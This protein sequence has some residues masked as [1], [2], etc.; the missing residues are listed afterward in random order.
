MLMRRSSKKRRSPK[1][2]GRETHKR[3]PLKRETRRPK[4]PR[5]KNRTWTNP[6]VSPPNA[7]PRPRVSSL[8]DPAHRVI[9]VRPVT[10]ARSA[11][12]TDPNV[13]QAPAMIAPNVPVR[14][15]QAPHAT[16]VRRVPVRPVQ[17]LPAHAHR[18]RA[19]HPA[20][21]ALAMIVR[22]A[23]ARAMIV[24]HVQDHPV[25]DHPAPAPRAADHPDQDRP[26][27]DPRAADRPEVDHPVAAPA[28]DHPAAGRVKADSKYRSPAAPQIATPTV[29]T[30]QAFHRAP[31]PLTPSVPPR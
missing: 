14:P 11:P 28:Q 8:R 10:T 15:D 9:S 13:S 1:I 4:S 22:N 5:L 23:P 12:A 24:H 18:V 3:K 19:A 7:P 2:L 26:A 21:V 25:Q 27:V 17:D 16:T 6:P 30:G 29:Q 20:S 31:A